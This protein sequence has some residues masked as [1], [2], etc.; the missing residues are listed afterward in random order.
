VECSEGDKCQAPG[1]VS[2][3]E[4]HDGSLL[5]CALVPVGELRHNCGDCGQEL[6]DDGD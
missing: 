1:G 6:D 5:T 3:Y 2:S 4:Q